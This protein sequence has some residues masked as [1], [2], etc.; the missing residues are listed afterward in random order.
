M[1]LWRRRHFSSSDHLASVR[2]AFD[3]RHTLQTLPSFHLCHACLSIPPRCFHFLKYFLLWIE[4]QTVPGIKSF[5][6]SWSTCPGARSC[7]TQGTWWRARLVWPLL[8]WTPHP[9]TPKLQ[10]THSNWWRHHP[11][12]KTPL[13]LGR[14]FP[15][16]FHSN[17]GNFS[18]GATFF[19]TSRWLHWALHFRMPPFYFCF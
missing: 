17:L 19:L 14:G 5:I 8:A 12:M 1:P 10:R 18:P 2:L 13:P 11:K 4:T 16:E 9:C 15:K 6:H 7:A 3:S